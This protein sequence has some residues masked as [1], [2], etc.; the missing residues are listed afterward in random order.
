MSVESDRI[1]SIV[2]HSPYPAIPLRR[3][4]YF[5]GIFEPDERSTLAHRN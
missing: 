2:S 3:E 5:L 1:G 4:T